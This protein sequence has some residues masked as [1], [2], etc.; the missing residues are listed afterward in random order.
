MFLVLFLLT[1]W[2]FSIFGCKE[3]NHTEFGVDH[4]TECGPL[5]KGMANYFSILA[6][7]T[8]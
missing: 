3:Y 7:R 6:L 8:P 1:V 5:E 2:S 4:L